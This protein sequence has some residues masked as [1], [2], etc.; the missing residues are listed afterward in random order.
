MLGPASAA[1]VIWESGR[2]Q[3][4]HAPWKWASDLNWFSDIL[5]AW[6]GQ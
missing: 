3:L 2:A 4:H 1:D 6:C 5:L